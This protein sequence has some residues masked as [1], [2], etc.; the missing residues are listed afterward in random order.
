M[1]DA[2]QALRLFAGQPSP[3]N[4]Y[5]VFEVVRVDAGGED[6]IVVN[7]WTTAKQITRFRR[8]MNSVSALGTDARHGVERTT[9]PADPMSIPEAQE[10]ITRLLAKWLASK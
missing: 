2:R 7:G 9:P 5:R 6:R 4:L 1:F 10:F 8:T 3:G